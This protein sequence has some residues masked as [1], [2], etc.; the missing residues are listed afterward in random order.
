[1]HDSNFQKQ[2]SKYIAKEYAFLLKSTKLLPTQILARDA[3]IDELTVIH[4]NEVLL[5][6]TPRPKL[7]MLH[8]FGG[9]GAVFGKM[10]EHLSERFHIVSPDLPGMGFNTRPERPFSDLNS[11][12]EFF[13]GTIK[14]FVDSIGWK[15]FSLLGHSMGA[16]FSAHFFDRHSE[17]VEKLFLISPAGF[18]LTSEESRQLWMKKGEKMNF[19]ARRLALYFSNSIFEKKMSPFELGYDWLRNYF[20]LS[21]ITNKYFSNPRFN[22]SLEEREHMIEMSKYFIK[23]RQCGERCIGYCVTWGLAS[24]APIAGVLAR[25]PDRFGDVMLSYGFKD[26]MNYKGAYRDLRE[27]KAV[28]KVYRIEDSDHQ[29]P[30]QN[31]LKLSLCVI[32]FHSSGSEV[33]TFDYYQD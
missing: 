9:D 16:F 29:I 15:S 2:R 5:D 33:E 13:V 18:S 12:L 32:D 14:K 30:F 8:G 4:F 28:V 26:F 10:F 11:C 27:M 19:F 20:L 23:L 17:I 6:E 31:P 24:D 7:L 21:P 3:Q 1:M 25:H 22:F